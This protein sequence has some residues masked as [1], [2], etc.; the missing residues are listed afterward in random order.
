MPRTGLQIGVGILALAVTLVL[1]AALALL[2]VPSPARAGNTGIAALMGELGIGEDCT[3]AHQARY[4]PRPLGLTPEWTA[5][6]ANYLQAKC[7]EEQGD[8]DEA[9][10]AYREGWRDNATELQALW[11]M[12]L[13]RTQARQ[14]RHDKVMETLEGI[15][16]GPRLSSLTPKF[17]ELVTELVLTNPAF[18]ESRKLGLLTTYYTHVMPEPADT[19]LLSRL[20]DL[21]NASQEPAVAAQ[22]KEHLWANPAD[23][24]SA[25]KWAGLPGERLRD[26]QPLPPVSAYLARYRGMFKLRL[27]PQL[28]SELETVALPANQPAGAKDLGRL[29]FRALIRHRKLSHGGLQALTDSFVKRFHFDKRQQTVWALRF[30][31]RRNRIGPALKLLGTLE[32]IS[33]GDT[34]LPGLFALVANYNRGRKDLVTMRY[35]LDRILKEFPKSQEASDAYWKSF[36]GAYQRGDLP[37]ARSWLDRGIP[38][39]KPFHPVDRAR[40]YYWQGRL[41]IDDGNQDAGV[42]VWAKMREQWPYGYYSALSEQ[43]LSGEPLVMSGGGIRVDQLAHPRAPE[44]SALWGISPF[45]PALFLFSI[46]EMD[47]AQA[48]LRGVVRK[49]LS[50]EAVQEAAALFYYLEQHNLQLRLIA[51]HQLPLLRTSQLGDSDLWPRAFPRSHWTLLNNEAAGQ[52]VDPYFVLAIMREESRFYVSADSK[53][54]ARGL[55]QLMPNTAK[56]LAKQ[57]KMKIEED[58]IHHPETNIPLGVYYL[59]RVLKRFGHNPVYAAAAYNAGPTTMSRWLRQYGKLPLD[60]FVERIPYGE[61][62]R[63]VKRVYLSYFIYSKLY[64]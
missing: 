1:L 37:A 27:F 61:T 50:E 14:E 31:L 46:G 34:E 29:Y 35:W 54:G 10:D 23:K 21:A 11:G 39:S 19:V 3:Q 63:Y 36:W 6:R 30:Q 18:P 45:P 49:K 33:P 20:L 55:M 59:G 28:I 51:N 48:L 7:L 58:Q 64:R 22:V 41:L 16:K 40:L 62:Q 2:A 42:A 52:G 32:K 5:M 24:A 44:L 38:A 13:L 60:V 12:G 8:L 47:A 43:V 17:R 56:A 4:N 25:V 53:V 15:L 26:K 57:R 9:A